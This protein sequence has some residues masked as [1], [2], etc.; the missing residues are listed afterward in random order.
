MNYRNNSF[1]LSPYRVMLCCLLIAGEES[2]DLS[3]EKQAQLAD[4]IT[5]KLQQ[6]APELSLKEL[7][8]DLAQLQ[9]LL[10]SALKFLNSEHEATPV[11]PD[12]ISLIFFKRIPE[13]LS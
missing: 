1:T 4:Y 8:E 12:S 2:L 11:H 6:G 13:V 3:K 7:R 9:S 10:P 5:G